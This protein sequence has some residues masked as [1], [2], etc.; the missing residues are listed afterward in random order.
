MNIYNL[1]IGLLMSIIAFWLFV[2]EMTKNKR[3]IDMFKIQVIGSLFGLFLFGIYLIFSE[4]MKL[5]Q[6]ELV[7]TKDPKNAKTVCVKTE[8]GNRKWKQKVGMKPKRKL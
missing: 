4:V 2:R 6:F 8:S 5:Q 1:L 3:S 7:I